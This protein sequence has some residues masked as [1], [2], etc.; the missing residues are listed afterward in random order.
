MVHTSAD[1]APL[2]RARLSGSV[3]LPP[4]YEP[5]WFL[6]TPRGEKLWADGW[7]PVFPAPADDDTEPGTVFETAHG[8]Q[9]TTWVVCAREPGRSVR[10]ARLAQG[11]DAGTVTV[12]LDDGTGPDE[13]RVATVEYDLTALSAEAATELARFAAGYPQF[14]RHWE[15]AIA[16][17][18]RIPDVP[19]LAAV[20]RPPE[21][22]DSGRAG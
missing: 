8:P 5:A 16:A 10:Y 6:F 19:R 7:D 20:P 18:T 17:A 22:E 11:R 4:G 15:E 14:L 12:T 13:S 2:T 1:P 21:P 3:R 9:R